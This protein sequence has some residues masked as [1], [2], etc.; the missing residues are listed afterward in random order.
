MK[1]EIRQSGQKVA[2]SQQR[3]ISHQQRHVEVLEKKPGLTSTVRVTF[4]KARQQIGASADKMHDVPQPVQGKSYIV[5]RR[6]NQQLVITNADGGETPAAEK[7]V[8]Q[9]AMEGVGRSNPMGEFLH[10]KTIT[11]GQTVELPKEVAA[12][13]F[14]VG[15]NAGPENI[16]RFSLVLRNIGAQLDRPYAVFDTEI[17]MA[18]PQIPDAETKV[19]GRLILDIASCRGLSADISGPL[20]MVEQR[21]PKQAPFTVEGH[22]QMQLAT[23]TTFE[24]A[25]R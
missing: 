13:M 19:S 8:V 6:A 16:R 17:A 23:R 3:M 14:A 12:S 20:H 1:T 22:G 5:S 10:G 15:G 25:I 11:I 4:D 18:D 7:Q 2:N 24:T 21:G 9:T